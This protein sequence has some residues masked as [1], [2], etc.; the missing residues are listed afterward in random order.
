MT[1]STRFAGKVAIVT[2][3]ANGIGRATA[4]RLADEGAAVAIFDR[5][6]DLAKSTAAKLPKALGFGVDVTDEAAVQTAV[7]AVVAEWGRIDFLVN[8]AG[9]AMI[10]PKPFWEYDLRTVKF[11]TDVNYFSQW[12]C[13]KAVLPAMRAGGAAG[14]GGLRGG[15]RIVNISSGSA[16][17]TVDG[18]AAYGAAKAAIVNMTHA[19][20]KELGA[21]NITVNAIAPGF[22]RFRREKGIFSEA[23][24]EQMMQGVKATQALQR[25][26]EP[27]DI[28]GV[29]AFLCSADAQHISGQVLAVDGGS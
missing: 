4:Q 9:G 20:A 24:M 12:I 22:I 3:G 23:Q 18:M 5:L 1:V 16:L 13:T 26:G 27:E 19:M 10:S 29:V 11:I 6:A 14:G 21:D 17:R 2:G 8:N 25:I 15:G 7:D 28:A